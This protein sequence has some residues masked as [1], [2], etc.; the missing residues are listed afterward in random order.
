MSPL[1]T[2]M[3]AMHARLGPVRT[4]LAFAFGILSIGFGVVM[5]VQI[6][7]GMMV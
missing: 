3:V 7:R 1:A 6:A 2:P 5:G 4:R